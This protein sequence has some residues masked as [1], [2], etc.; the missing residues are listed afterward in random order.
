[1]YDDV[2]STRWVRSLTAGASIIQ[3]KEARTPPLRC[4]FRRDLYGSHHSRRY[5][6]GIRSRDPHPHRTA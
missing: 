6:G 3:N 1:M 4:P 2:Q 5:G